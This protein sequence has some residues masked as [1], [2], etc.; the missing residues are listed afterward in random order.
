MPFPEF[1]QEENPEF[2]IENPTLTSE[3]VAKFIAFLMKNKNVFASTLARLGYATEYQH[4]I[5]INDAKPVTLRFYRTS[6]KIK[7]EIDA[8][9]KELL[10]HGIIEPWTNAWSSPVVMVRMPDGSYCFAVDYRE[11]NHRTE[12]RNF[13]LP[14]LSDIFDQIGEAK[15]RYF[16]VLDMQSGFW[17]MPVNPADKDKTAFVTKNAKYVFN[18]M[19]FGLKPAPFA[20]QQCTSS[21]LKDLLGKSCCVYADDIL[22][23]SPDLETHMPDLQMIIDRLA[24]AGLTL[25]PSKCK[26]ATQE[27]KCLSHILCPT[28]IRVNPEKIEVI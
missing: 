28:G 27:V 22:C 1:S 10:C 4:S 13:P 11:L 7:K 15:P 17:Q 18:R 14:R 20:F 6:P 21:V 5:E 25:K 23:Y 19:P 16:S 26:F 9:I 24:K 8:Q 2:N 12:P 3:D